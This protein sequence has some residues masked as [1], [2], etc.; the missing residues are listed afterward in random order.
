YVDSHYNVLFHSCGVVLID[1]FVSIL[2]LNL[3]EPA[4]GADIAKLEYKLMAGEH[5]LV[6]RVKGLNLKTACFLY[7]QLI[8]DRLSDFSF[9]PAVFEMIKE[10]LKK[11]FNMLIKS[12]VL[13]K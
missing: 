8:I 12:E 7:S 2:S 9:T 4:Y 5:G 10:E 3:S 13:A 11:D 6:I 1:T